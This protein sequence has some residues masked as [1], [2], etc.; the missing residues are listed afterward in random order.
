MNEAKEEAVVMN[1]GEFVDM[2]KKMEQDAIQRVEEKLRAEGVEI[3][4]E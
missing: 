3:P 1:D 2:M 4:K